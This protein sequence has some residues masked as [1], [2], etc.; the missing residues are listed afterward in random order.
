MNV[1]KEKR[2]HAEVALVG[3]IPASEIEKQ[4]SKALAAITKEIALPGFRKGHVPTERVL[5]EVGEK[6]IWRE[7]AEIALNENLEEILKKNEIRPI[8]P[9]ALSMKSADKGADVSFEIVATVAPSVTVNDYRAL[10]KKALDAI[11]KEDEG[12]ERAEAKKAF[13][14]QLAGMFQKEAGAAITDDDAKSM[15]FESAAAL[16]LFIDDQAT[17]AIMDRAIQKRRASVAEALIKDSPADIPTF[18]IR[19]EA[20]ALL[21]ATKKDIAGQGTNWNDYLKHFKKTEDTLLTDLVPQA[22]KR[23]ALDLIFSE[24]IKKEELKFEGEEAKKA[25]DE[26]AHRIAHQGVDHATAHAYARESLL[27]EKVWEVL[28]VKS[29]TKA[30]IKS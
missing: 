3:T 5:Q 18:V 10:A 26:L 4:W 30:D 22:E 24:I 8:A 27:R 12:K 1:A 25:E 15:G 6:S 2:P 17:H 13:E 23:I 28:G 11:P 7:A 14:A 29:E 19:D 20:A 9:L 16:N 21:E